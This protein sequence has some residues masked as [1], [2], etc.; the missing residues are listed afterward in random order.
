MYQSYTHL[1]GSV[2]FTLTSAFQQTCGPFNNHLD[3]IV[4]QEST[5]S[6]LSRC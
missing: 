5:L 3:S 1:S 6:N 4:A 2:T